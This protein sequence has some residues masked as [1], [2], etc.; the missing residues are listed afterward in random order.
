M[1]AIHD[2][3]VYRRALRERGITPSNTR[4]GV[5]HGSGLGHVRWV[6]EQTFVWLHQFKRLRIRY[7]VRADL[8]LGLLQSACAL[9]CYR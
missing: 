1:G 3:D 2:C 7:E 6:V 9:I 4:R 8:H 5:A